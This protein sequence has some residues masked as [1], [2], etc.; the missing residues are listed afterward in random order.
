MNYV[1][2]LIEVI[3]IFLLLIGFYK[4]GKKDGLFLYIGLL[5]SLICIL[6]FKSIDIFSFEI[7]L[8]ISFVIGI[9]VC[10]NI[11]VQRYGID[12]TKDIIKAFV[13]PYIIT[14]VLLS[15]V[16]LIDSSDYNNITN[17]YY[18][19]LFGYNLNNLRLLIG[20][21]LSILFAL[22]Y[23]SYV[24]HSLRK[25]KNKLIINHMGS[26]FVIQFIESLI[27]VVISYVGNFGFDMLFG[28]VVI[29]YLLKIIIGII[30]FIPFVLVL[31]M[32]S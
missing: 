18:D 21:F 15:L 3:F 24:Y 14:I 7:N 17:S 29:S 4:F 12:E 8:G 27:F 20:A 31:K 9:F 23:N 16:S 6:M 1:Y 2:L 5:S 28:M 22:W 30:G 32:K 13:F 10:S 25:N 11:I 26:M 19:L